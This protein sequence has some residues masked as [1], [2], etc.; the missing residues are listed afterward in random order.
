MV[1]VPSGSP[2]HG[3]MADAFDYD[4]FWVEDSVLPANTSDR[5]SV[6][7]HLDKRRT[8][9]ALLDLQALTTEDDPGEG[10]SG[11]RS[12]ASTASIISC[13]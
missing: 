2:H 9:M 5:H 13:D 8:T 3:C 4:L 11:E 10:L 1:I 7:E 12:E 6:A